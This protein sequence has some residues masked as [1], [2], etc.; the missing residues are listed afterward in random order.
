MEKPNTEMNKLKCGVIMPISSIDGCTESHWSD[1]MD[2]IK[3]CVD[4][5]GFD[6]NIVSN[7]DDVGVIHKRIVQNL[8]DNPIVVCDV[9]CRNP[10]VMFELGMRLAFDK[11][12]II[13]KD[14][15]T[16]YSFDT[17][18]IEHIEY[19][20]DLRFNKIEE[21]KLKL[22]EKI[23][24]TYK[25]STEDP[26]F[27]TFLKNFGEF[28]VAKIDT[29]EVSQQEL[30]MDELR[31]LRRMI[32]NS[33]SVNRHKYNDQFYYKD[34]I[35]DKGVVDICLEELCTL[36][37]LEKSMGRILSLPGVISSEI[38]KRGEDHIHLILRVNPKYNTNEIEDEVKRY[39]SRRR[40]LNKSIS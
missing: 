1:V 18:S 22:I 34:N 7:A 4:E 40:I 28:K 2:I 9:S 35:E 5:S 11:P 10:N 27:S 3:T 38:D 23:K 17:S 21:F 33:N 16:S 39:L 37:T 36:E 24:S 19:P 8:Y 6:A 15:K 13:I 12:T 20:R 25:K 32:V 26:N 31:S 29:K 30:V 14:D